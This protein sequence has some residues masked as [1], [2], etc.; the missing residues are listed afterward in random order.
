MVSLIAAAGQFDPERRGQTQKLTIKALG[1]RVVDKGFKFEGKGSRILRI[2]IE[3]RNKRQ[4]SFS[5]Q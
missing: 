3:A 4:N 5:S 1:N 2:I